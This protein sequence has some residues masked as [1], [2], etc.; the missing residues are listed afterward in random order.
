MHI[1]HIASELAPI[2][3]VG[4]L[5]DVI[6][7]LSKELTKNGH[8]VEIILPKYDCI[9]YSLLKN[10]RVHHRE[11]WSFDGPYRYN[12]TI[13]SAEVE[14]LNILLI[15]PHHPS[16]YFS[17]GSV[18]GSHDD[19]DRFLYFSRTSM[20][21]L[22]KSERTPDVI[23]VHDWPTAVVPLLY[24]DMYIPLGFKAG[25]IMLTLHNMEHQG[26]CN[27]Q[28]I[29]RIGLRGENYLSPEKLQDPHSPHLLNLLKGGIEYAHGITTVSPNYEEEI[30][31]AHGGHG[32]HLVLS[33]HQKKLKGIL[34]GIDEDFW[35]PEQ[36]PHLVQKYETHPPY[37][38]EKLQ[39][40]IK[41]KQENKQHLRKQLQMAD[42]KRPMVAAI[43][44][45]VHQK[46]PFLIAHAIRRTLEQDGQ[47][48]LLGSAHSVETLRLFSDMQIEFD[49]N[50][51]VSIL[52]DYNEALAHQIF[53]AADM[54]IIPSLFEP[55]GLTQMIALRYGTIPIVR[56]TGGLADTIFDIETSSAPLEERNG[57]V[58]DHPDKEGV[59]WALDRA[60]AYWK[61]D[62]KKWA[63]LIKQGI[64]KDFSWK[65]ATLEYQRLYEKSMQIE[66]EEIK[67]LET[68]KQDQNPKAFLI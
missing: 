45:L 67:D 29:T 11:L 9:D 10:L 54:L 44:R 35:N 7:G 1:V 30:K 31:T 56:K 60:L 18:Y 65:Q 42:A 27:P 49:D 36:D 28:N 26:K 19:I 51:N 33:K 2:A 55:C 37:T 23:H 38:A 20:E 17:R 21:F 50:P 57:F 46:S 34:N 6:Y 48:V 61:K 14:N 66:E 24:K 32:L 16:Y 59:N 13:W 47:F 40:I 63:Q 12:N 52:L 64:K 15:E 4:G 5:G 41:A 3:K 58:F 39:Q 53:S 43:T 68:T 8:K 62:P 25:C 22:F